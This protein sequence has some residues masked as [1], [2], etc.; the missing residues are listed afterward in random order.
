MDI[1]RAHPD[2]TE[3]ERQ[4]RLASRWLS[5]ELMMKAFGWDVTQMGY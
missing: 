1:R 3:R 5:P 4:L 2:A